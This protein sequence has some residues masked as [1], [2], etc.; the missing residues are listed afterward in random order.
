[1][2]EIKPLRAWRFNKALTPK[3][4]ELTSPLFDVVSER[5]RDALYKNEINSI[6]L[7]VP[8]EPNAAIRAAETLEKWKSDGTIA[9]DPLP[10]IY[11]YYQHF[12][13]PGSDKEYCRKGFIANLRVYDW[14]DEVLLRHENTMPHSV[15]DRVDLL[16]KTELNVS[17]THGLYTDEE[18]E[19]ERYMD[20]SMLHPIYE[21]EDYQGVRDV[22]SVIHDAGVIKKFMRVLKEK[23]VI[24]ADGHH[25]YEGSLAY[26]HEMIKSNPDHTGDE[27]YNFHL[28]FFTNTESDDLRILPTHR[29][30]AGWD[31][32]SEESL[33]QKLSEY[34]HI[35]PVENPSD[36]NEI[37]LGKQWAYGLLVGDR[38]VKI[39]LKPELIDTIHWNFPD[40]IKRMDLTVMH[41]FV[42][43]KV[44]GIPGPKQRGSE[45][46]T[47]HRNFTECHSRV[48]K[49]EAQ[50]AVITK[51][52]S[53]D[54]VKEICYS[55]YTMPPKST[56]FYP[57]VICGFLFSSIN[58]EEFKLPVDFSV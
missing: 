39:R 40:H 46:I 38:A 50:F 24:L 47:F 3:I 53:I 18:H 54:T 12:N 17:P 23:K 16:R 43:E 42:F 49:G 29:I 51:E 58:D 37:I 44:M 27:G 48:L 33:L 9:Q 32:F 19:L 55:G 57:K 22:L 31:S 15:N 10:G 34:F 14:E 8:Q 56:Y 26:K 20:E 41:Y 35:K 28:M 30:V 21:T 36:V 25:R 45:L 2:A 52:M 13:L 6:H 4:E 11:V 1:M 5:Q 7:S